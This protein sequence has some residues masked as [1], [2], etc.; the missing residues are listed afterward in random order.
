MNLPKEK[1]AP[2]NQKPFLN[3][4]SQYTDPMPSLRCFSPALSLTEILQH[5]FSNNDEPVFVYHPEKLHRSVRCFIENFPGTVGYSV[6]ANCTPAILQDLYRA[7]IRLF[8]AASIPEMNL[9]FGALSAWKDAELSFSNACRKNPHITPAYA[10]G[11]R[12]FAIDSLNELEKLLSHLSPNRETIVPVRIKAPFYE[13]L[14]NQP[15]KF[16]VAFEEARSLLRHVHRAGFTPALTFHVGAF[17]LNPKSY[18]DSLD[19]CLALIQDAENEGIDIDYIN[20]G[21]GYPVDGVV[22]DAPKLAVF[23]ETIASYRKRIPQKVGFMCEPGRALV[24]DS[25]SLLV[26]VLGVKHHE[27]AV[28]ISDGGEHGN[29]REYHQAVKNVHIPFSLIPKGTSRLIARDNKLTHYRLYGFSCDCDMVPFTLPLPP[30]LVP[31]DR[32]LLHQMGA[33]SSVQNTR[34][35]GN[36]VFNLMFVERA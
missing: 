29:L 14:F 34:F 27:N 20:M 32:I 22:E 8:D 35:N 5:P 30:T 13:N 25:Q 12:H 28:Y 3:H 17:S 11:V 4:A 26:T 21:G 24:A 18:A 6:K 16:G 10:M 19:M 2:V 36:G 23:L 31:G 33:Y 7:G 1:R 9:I 15:H